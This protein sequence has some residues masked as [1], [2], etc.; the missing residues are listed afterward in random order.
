MFVVTSLSDECMERYGYATLATWVENLPCDIWV[1]GESEKSY[2]HHRKV[3]NFNLFHE[4]NVGQFLTQIE[5]LPI[6]HG[7]VGN[8][9]NYNLDAWKFCRKVFAQVDACRKIKGRVFW[10]DTDVMMHKPVPETFLVKL[11]QD[12]Y[13]CY[14]G[15]QGIYPECGFIGWDTRYKQ[16]AEFMDVYEN[17][18]LNGSILMMQAWHD[19]TAFEFVRKGLN[20]PSR[21]LSRD[22]CG[23]HVWPKTMLA[24]Y[25]DHLKGPRKQQ[26]EERN[27]GCD[28]EP[29]LLA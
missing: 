23:L 12:V 5:R 4:T 24:D 26:I 6:A 18:F 16:N 14:L 25:M 21:N 29:L 13:L 27:P 11:L 10:I 28:D 2:F 3:H 17:I 8:E 9:Y 7:I 15:R 22:I 20:V 19:C 1:Y